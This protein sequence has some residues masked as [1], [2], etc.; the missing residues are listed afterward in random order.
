MTATPCKYSPVSH[1]PP[2][3]CGGSREGK[4]GGEELI[5][6]NTG[7]TPGI[8]ATPGANLPGA[9][10]MAAILHQDARADEGKERKGAQP[11]LAALTGP[12]AAPKNFSSVLPISYHVAMGRRKDLELR[13]KWDTKPV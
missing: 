5:P 3:P 11:L 9:T 1:S 7:R 13:S 4:G 10:R 8:G 12:M 2:P 6:A